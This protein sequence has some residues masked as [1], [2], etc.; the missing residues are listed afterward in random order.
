[1]TKAIAVNSAELRGINVALAADLAQA[2]G[3]SIGDYVLIE[4]SNG[5]KAPGVV[6]RITSLYN[7]CLLSNE[8]TEALGLSKVDTVEVTKPQVEYAKRIY[9]EIYEGRLI[10]LKNL[11]MH[12]Y[13]IPLL[14]KTKLLISLDG[15][16]L[17]ALITVDLGEESKIYKIDSSTEINAVAIN[18]D[19]KGMEA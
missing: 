14:N 12:L 18:T 4:A 5:V 1:M 15:E 3:V 7:I 10:D 19:A 11:R 16:K 2:I 13:D 8:L 9:V 6:S 17:R